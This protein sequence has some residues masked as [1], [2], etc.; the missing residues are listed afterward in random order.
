[1]LLVQYVYRLSIYM[2]NVSIQKHIIFDQAA[3]QINASYWI[4]S[5]FSIRI[6]HTLPP[7][8]PLCSSP[9]NGNMASEI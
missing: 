5:E 9:H 6:Q 1:M 8:N 4:T 7:H 2:N 3:K